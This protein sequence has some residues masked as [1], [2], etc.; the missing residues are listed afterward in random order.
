M[1]ASAVTS[2]ETHMASAAATAHDSYHPTNTTWFA[3][4]VTDKAT[5]ILLP[6]VNPSPRDDAASPQSP[7]AASV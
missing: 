4:T 2:D 1:A 7:S 3:S 6:K 5:E